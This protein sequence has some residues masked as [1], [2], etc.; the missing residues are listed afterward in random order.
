M[1]T[2]IRM[3]DGT[4]LATDI[5]LPSGK[6]PW[7]VRLIRTPY[8][9]THYAQQYGNGR[10]SGYAMVIQDMRGRFD[11][12]G[13]DLPFFESGWGQH[14][15]GLDTIK[16]ISAQPWCNGKIGTQGSS[17]MG[18]TQILLAA[19]HSPQVKAQYIDVATS[20][21]YH[22]AV[23]P[24][25][26]LGWAL[27]MG[28]LTG[29]NFDHDNVWLAALHPFYDGHWKLLD[30]GPR[31]EI[32]EQP[33][34]F[35]GGWYDIFIQGTIDAFLERQ[36]RG[37]PGARGQQKLIIGPWPHRGPSDEPVGEL[38]FPKQSKRPPFPCDPEKWFDHYLKGKENGIAQ[39]PAVQYYTMGAVGERS[40]PGN[41]WK[42]AASWPVPCQE[43]AYY[44]QPKGEL[45]PES[46]SSETGARAYVYDPLD[47]VPTIG[48]CLLT[49]PAGSYDQR[50]IEQRPDVVTFTT[51]E[52]KK[53][54]EIT[55]RLKAHLFIVSDCVDTDFAAKLTDV[56]PDGRSMLIADG[57]L[58]CR[59]RDGADRQV[60]LTP[61][62]PTP[63]EIDLWSTSIVMAK[64]HRL[65]VA[66]SSSNYP[67]FDTNLNTGWPGW[68]MGS[69]R[70]AHNQVLCNRAHPSHII[71]PVIE[72]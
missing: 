29:M 3:A 62:N 15:D 19:S 10:A 17:A 68:P 47:P 71:L 21:L 65:R 66:V 72:N 33:A 31:A 27:M 39:I 24:G 54:L 34:V 51:D 49:L 22:S 56:Y 23:Y 67:R 64:E 46:P 13:K 35:S 57:L 9:R 8:N 25:G 70:V 28:W 50:A 14:Q 43:V 69:L 52:F 42:T 11:S 7:P 5:Y 38:T 53:P 2:A 1:V 60:L 16:W 37:G 61:G 45:K 12:E 44:F 18:I 20:S 59:Y 36:T 41:V 55:G 4:P 32:V 48:G 63:I 40:A 26:G 30:A 58:R 6:G